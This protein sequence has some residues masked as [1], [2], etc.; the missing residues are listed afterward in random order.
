[1]AGIYRIFDI[2]MQKIMICLLIYNYGI[3]SHF[4]FNGGVKLWLVQVLPWPVLLSYFK[5]VW[6]TP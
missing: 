6:K 2:A 3:L 5:V 1:M 4:F